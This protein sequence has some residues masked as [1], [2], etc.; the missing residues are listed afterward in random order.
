MKLLSL[1][2]ENRI[3]RIVSI[4]IGAMIIVVSIVF[5]FII[6]FYNLEI[7][8]GYKRI[9]VDV[10]V[11]ALSFLVLLIIIETVSLF[12]DK[13]ATFHTLLISIFAF[14]A[15]GSSKDFTWVFD[16]FNVETAAIWFNSIR[17]FIFISS[18]SGMVFFL[19]MHL[20]RTFD[21]RYSNAEFGV[22]LSFTALALVI[23]LISNLSAI[24]LGKVEYA[25]VAI[26]LIACSLKVIFSLKFMNS[27]KINACLI[28]LLI[29]IAGSFI[30]G[31]FVSSLETNVVSGYG[32]AALSAI[33]IVLVFF[34]IYL[35][36][37]LRTT[38]NAYKVADVEKKISELQANV[39]KERIMPHFIFNTLNVVKNLYNKNV[40]KGNEA[41]DLLSKH[42]RNYVDAGEEYLVDFQKE[43][44][45]V[46]TFVRIANI[47]GGAQFA[48]IYDIDYFDF[49]V[50]SFSIEP[51]IENAIKYST[52]DLKED[53]YIGITTYLENDVIH[54][55]IVDNGVGFDTK[56][57]R[58]NGHGIN[59]AKERFAL[60][61][62][63]E[64]NISSSPNE[65]TKI[66]ILIPKESSKNGNINN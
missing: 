47:R 44:E 50:P 11:I 1:F 38:R 19:F 46:E 51:F 26:M 45:F 14:L 12:V 20:K 23:N 61:L 16:R 57:I 4:L 54:I 31:E 60:L 55:E 18:V 3:T 10:S 21:F 64:T 48:I 15:L 22:Y 29:P 33:Y 62:K 5:S 17:S 9:I 35:D 59:N 6:G 49:K 65:G 27:F 52:V 42:L 39:L 7:N 13:D 63:A 40:E 37:L 41:I 56:K 53:G 32:V 34:T 28:F 43:L 58:K 2:K 8:A 66:E 24:N 36:F 25:L 30:Y